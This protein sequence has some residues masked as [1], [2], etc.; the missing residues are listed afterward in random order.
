M[1]TRFVI[2]ENSIDL[3]GLDAAAG[4]EVIE[5]LLDRVEDAHFQGHGVCFDDELFHIAVVA[6]RSFW[7]LCDPASPVHLPPEVAQRAAAAFSAMPRWYE[8]SATWPP[9]VDVKVEGG[10]VETTASVAWAHQQAVM[11]GLSCVACICASGRRRA[12]YV[13]VELAGQSETVWFVESARDMERYFRW[14]IA[15]HA[16]APHEIADLAPS[17]FTQLTFVD[18]CFNGIRTMSKPCRQLAPTI[19]HHLGAFSDEGRRIFSGDWM[20]VP[21]EFGAL[22]VDISDENGATKRNPQAR[23]ERRLVVDGEEVFFWWHSKIEP[24][25]DRIYICPDK[26]PKG[27][28]IIV[29]SL[30]LHLTI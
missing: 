18:R 22:G 4:L 26:V 3:N 1:T 7:E 12:G 25:Q 13:T 30:C 2:D 8:V 19:A 10:P 29:A 9:D 21:A 6:E 27:G 5:V 15:Q 28:G 24:H 14:L 20:R 23:R 16:T 17:A 11:G